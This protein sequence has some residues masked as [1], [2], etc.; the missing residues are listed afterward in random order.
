MK[1]K[2]MTMIL[3]VNEEVGNPVG[4]VLIFGLRL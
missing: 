4:E 2:R 3:A 1:T